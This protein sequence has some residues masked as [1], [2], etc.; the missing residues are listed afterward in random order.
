MKWLRLMG[1]SVRLEVRL[2]RD[3]DIGDCELRIER[4]GGA[5]LCLWRGNNYA[6]ALIVGSSFFWWSFCAHFGMGFEIGAVGGV[7]IAEK[8]GRFVSFGI[9]D[10]NL[11]LMRGH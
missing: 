3:V 4:S 6:D 1:T 2:V 8:G 7:A 5:I 10:L 11:A 9:A